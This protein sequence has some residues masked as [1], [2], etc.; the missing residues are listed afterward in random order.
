MS[1]RERRRKSRSRQAAITGLAVGAT[2][3]GGAMTAETALAA[4]F[5]VSNLNDSGAGSLRQAIL[6]SNAA[7]GPDQILFASGLSGH[8]TLASSLPQITQPLDIQGPSARALTVS[9]NSNAR[10]LDVHAPTGPCRGTADH[11]VRDRQVPV[12]D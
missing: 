5:T 4:P 8:I 10:I 6:D 3:A 7:A 1:L 12:V 9:G 2:L 11:R